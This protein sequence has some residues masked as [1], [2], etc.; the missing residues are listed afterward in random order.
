MTA[1]SR[2]RVRKL[3]ALDLCGYILK[4]DS[5]SCGMERVKVRAGDGPG[6][7]KGVGLFA[8]ELMTFFPAE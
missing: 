2:R 6:V 7:R 5:P 4:K 1:F 3:E 8:R